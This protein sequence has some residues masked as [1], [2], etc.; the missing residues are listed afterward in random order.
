MGADFDVVSLKDIGCHEELPETQQ[1]IEGNSRQ[2]AEFVSEHYNVDCFADDTGLE[3]AAL[4][5]DPGVYSARYAGPDCSSEDNMAL[6]LD[7]LS[8][9]KDRS[10]Q[11]KTVITLCLDGK[12]HSFTGVVAGMITDERKG[13]DGFGYDPI[14]IPEGYRETFAEM[15]SD[16]KNQISHRA[17]ATFELVQ[18]LKQL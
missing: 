6:L 13:T 5:G 18:F 10:A 15:T 17:L 11:F 7:N 1:T 16:M 4:K 14:F 12:Y 2:K 3:V 9:I 8:E